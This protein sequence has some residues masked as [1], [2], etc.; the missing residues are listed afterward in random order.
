L[1]EDDKPIIGVFLRKTGSVQIIQEPGIIIDNYKDDLALLL[2]KI[3]WKQ[4]FVTTPLK[5]LIQ[6]M[7]M[8][9]RVHDGAFIAACTPNQYH[10][11]ILL[12]EKPTKNELSNIDLTLSGLT[13][14]ALSIDD[15]DDVIAIYLEVF[16]GFASYDY[17]VEKL[18][19]GRGRAIGGYA[20]GNLVT[21]A[22]SDYEC[23][24]SAIV[25]G[26]ATRITSQGKGYGR[27][28]FEHLCNQLILMDK[29]TVYLQYDAPVAGALYK[30]L[31]FENV[32]QIFHVE[33]IEE[34]NR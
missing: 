11:R 1:K 25:V 10:P 6:G 8:E 34:V 18:K 27:L 23:S 12:S 16:K 31:G 4:A 28:C 5:I 19:S 21:V 2:G 15:L 32:E 9:S 29:K 13:I 3:Q 24:D 22:Q 20:D 14:K 17:M 33:K 26:V 7:Q 30:S